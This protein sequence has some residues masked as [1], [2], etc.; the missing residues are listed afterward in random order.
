VA[1]A[2]FIGEMSRVH[3]E[4]HDEFLPVARVRRLLSFGLL[5]FGFDLITG[6]S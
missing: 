3:D 6:S 2:N 4:L 1:L 5:L